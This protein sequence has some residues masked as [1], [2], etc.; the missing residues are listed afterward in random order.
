LG[1]YGLGADK[2]QAARDI[3]QEVI[4]NMDGVRYDR[5][6]FQKFGDYSLDFEVV[7]YVLSKDYTQYMDLQHAINMEIYRRFEEEEIPFAFPTQTL[8]HRDLPELEYSSQ[9]MGS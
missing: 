6:H 1:E 8:H 4:E 5:A 2:V 9:P 3:A 7:Y